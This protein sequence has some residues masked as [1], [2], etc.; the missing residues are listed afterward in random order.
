MA[1]ATEPLRARPPAARAQRPD[2]QRWAHPRAHFAPLVRAATGSLGALVARP[3]SRPVRARHFANATRTFVPRVAMVPH[4][5][6]SSRGTLVARAAAVRAAPV[7]HP[8]C[9]ATAVRRSFALTAG[10][11]GR[12]VRA[13]GPAPSRLPS[14]ESARPLMVYRR[15]TPEAPTR[16]RNSNGKDE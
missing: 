1:V 12:A 9:R 10:P 14:P 15:R 6:R 16:A 11:R 4:A 13:R 3:L 5:A 7:G 2:A 8:S